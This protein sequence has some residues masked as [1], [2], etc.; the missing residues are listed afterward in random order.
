MIHHFP[1][2]TADASV[3]DLT[4]VYKGKLSSY[5]RPLL[6]T[7]TGTLFLFDQVKSSSSEV[8]YMIGFFM[9]LKMK[10]MNAK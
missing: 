8:M 1:G 3:A 7:K 9:H 10:V 6:Y 2:K 5:T 4:G